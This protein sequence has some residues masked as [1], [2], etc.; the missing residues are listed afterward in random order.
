MRSTGRVKW[1]NAEKGFGFIT[2]EAGGRDMFVHFSAIEG[3]GF[4]SLNENERVEFDVVPGEKGPQAAAVMRLE[5]AITTDS[6]V[7]R[8]PHD[9]RAQRDQLHQPDQ[10]DRGRNA[11]TWAKRRRN[12]W[13][14]ED[15]G[16]RR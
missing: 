8:A 1:F 7:V 16:R 15:R 3:S 14:D 10:P 9:D 5:A 12:E 4:R 6:S 11:K 2:P 13:D